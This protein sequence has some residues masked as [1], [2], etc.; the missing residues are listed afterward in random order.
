L[1]FCNSVSTIGLTVNVRRASLLS[2]PSAADTAD[3]PPPASRPRSVPSPVASPPRRDERSALKIVDITE[4]YS[5]RGGGI[6]SHL[7]NRGRFLSEH[8]CRHCVIAPG[9][10][11]DDAV[12]CNEVASGGRSRLVRLAGPALP[13]DR[14]YHLLHRVDRIRQ[15]VRAERPD[16]LEAHS[17]YLAAAA[18]AACGRGAA[19]LNTMFWHSDHVGVYIEPALS[20]H[21]GGSVA[22]FTA[23]VLW[24]GVRAMLSPFDA[25]F[26]AGRAQAEHL[27]AAGVP[28]VIHAPFG[29]DTRTFRPAA[30]ANEWRRKWLGDEHDGA[31]LLVGVG[32]FAMEK[33]WDV[34]LEAFARLR[35]R[36]KAVLV[37]FG[38][39]PERLALEGRACSGVRFAGFEQDRARLATALASADALVHGSPYETFGIG[40]AEAVACGLPI[41]VPDSGGAAEHAESSCSETYRSLDPAACAAAIESILNRG[42]RRTRSL[43]AA[44]RARTVEQHFQQV[45]GVYGDLLRE[46]KR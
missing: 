34:V 11:D 25:T 8:H 15:R 14:T 29:V 40:I 2:I 35:S 6:R 22:R 43:D 3:D 31:A 18:V 28:R 7:T 32:R 17:P 20:K 39:G 9:P 42:S 21:L 46:L 13:Y 44:A 4:F 19:R 36:R 16:V 41:V 24:K 10:Y 30:R 23:N 12:V 26:A 5:E 45:L 33:R 27:R 38:D 1:G 37:L